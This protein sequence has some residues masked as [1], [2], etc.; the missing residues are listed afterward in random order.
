MDFAT[1]HSMSGLNIPG[2]YPLTNLAAMF[3]LVKGWDTLCLLGTWNQIEFASWWGTI[4]S[5][6]RV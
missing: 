4:I 2:F 5:T 6:Q 1:I 3:R